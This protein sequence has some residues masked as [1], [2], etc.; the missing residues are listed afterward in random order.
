MLVGFDHVQLAIPPGGLEQARV[1]L[2]D[3]LG[4]TQVER[5]S[6]LS[7]EGAWFEAGEIRLHL[8]VEG[9]FHPARKAHPALRVEPAS[10]DA[11]L[12]KLRAAGVPVRVATDVP[13]ARRGFID[14]PFGNRIELCAR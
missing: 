10:W 9:D 3:I 4:M 7:G 2:V 14:D 1:F 6:E 8:G 13:G 11:Y 12:E 5:P